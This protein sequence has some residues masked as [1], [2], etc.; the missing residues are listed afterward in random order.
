MKKVYLA[1]SNRANPSELIAL[2]RQLKDL[3][4][5]V[6][7]YEGGHYSNEAMLECEYLIVLT[8][9]SGSVFVPKTLGKGLYTQI[10]DF[11][12]FTKYSKNV[13]VIVDSTLNSDNGKDTFYCRK[14]HSLEIRDEFNYLYYGLSNLVSDETTI[15]ELFGGNIVQLSNQSSNQYMYLL[16]K[17]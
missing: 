15:E 5:K 9:E 7:E 10:E 4:L 12:E 14:H 17:R 6:V 8:S 2:R 11:C 1:K 13:Y 3:G 16:A